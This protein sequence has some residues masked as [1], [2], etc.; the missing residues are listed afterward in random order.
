V[1]IVPF[2][3]ITDSSHRHCGDSARRAEP[4]ATCWISDSSR[5]HS[6]M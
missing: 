6:S 3:L 5:L 4:H 1:A 2:E